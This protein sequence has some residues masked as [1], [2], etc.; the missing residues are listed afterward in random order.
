MAPERLIFSLI[1][2]SVPAIAGEPGPLCISCGTAWRLRTHCAASSITASLSRR[3]ESPLTCV[4]ASALILL[5]RGTGTH[6]DLFRPIRV[7]GKWRRMPV[8]SRLLR[9]QFMFLSP[10]LLRLYLCFPSMV[11]LGTSAAGED[12]KGDR[13]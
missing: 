7:C 6:H 5:F 2:F 9:L 1:S 10:L 12:V 3:I 4:L 11:D 8:Q 13:L